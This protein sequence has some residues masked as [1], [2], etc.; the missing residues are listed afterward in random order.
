VLVVGCFGQDLYY[1]KGEV[2]GLFWGKMRSQEKIWMLAGLDVGNHVVAAWALSDLPTWSDRVY[3][4]GFPKISNGD[5]AK[6]LNRFYSSL[7]DV[8]PSVWLWF[9]RS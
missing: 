8:R 6:E 2:N 3:S 7:A 9:T 5:M 4:K 1:T